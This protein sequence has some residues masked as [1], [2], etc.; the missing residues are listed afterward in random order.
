[1]SMFR[2]EFLINEEA[3]QSAWEQEQEDRGEF[4]QMAEDYERETDDDRLRQ[5]PF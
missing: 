3:M 4:V 1:M 2:D 5:E